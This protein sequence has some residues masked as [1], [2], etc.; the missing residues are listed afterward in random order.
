MKCDVDGIGARKTSSGV[1][2]IDC[3]GLGGL[4]A[5]WV[6]DLE[7]ARKVLVIPLR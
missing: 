4:Y 3:V 2:S 6:L 1:S 5:P 7:V